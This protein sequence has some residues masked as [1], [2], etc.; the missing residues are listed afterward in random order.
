MKLR[1]V[2]A[3]IGVLCLLLQTSISAAT[4]FPEIRTPAPPAEPRINGPSVF[5]VRPGSPF[6]YRIPATAE[7]PIKFSA[8]GL[9][10]ELKLHSTTGQITGAF[11]K[12]GEHVVTLR[13]ENTKGASEKRFR[14]VVG[15]TIALTPPMG[16]NSWN[17]WGSR[18]DAEKV[19]RSAR[20]MVNSGLINH[21][22]TYINVDDAW[23]GKR[24]GPFNGIQGNEK[25][26][27][28]SEEHTSEL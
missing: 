9:P 12:A 14:I 22:W 28:R 27:D 4:D 8:S 25:F 7:R 20:G 3:A 24:G 16:W 10:K 21:G 11:K 23:Q 5:G 6:L 19:L 17:C 15:D 1:L 26:P 18:V 13:A 2:S